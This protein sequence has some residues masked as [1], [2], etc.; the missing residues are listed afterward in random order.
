MALQAFLRRVL[1]FLA[2]TQRAWAHI[3]GNVS[4]GYMG[5]I[6]QFKDAVKLYSSNSE[7]LIYF[8]LSLLLRLIVNNIYNIIVIPSKYFKLN[9]IF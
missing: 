1:C 2:E 9:F 5:Q 4:D 7:I 3:Y 6:N 8:I